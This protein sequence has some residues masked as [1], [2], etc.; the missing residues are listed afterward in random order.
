M[1]GL[2]E[3]LVNPMDGLGDLTDEQV[4]GILGEIAALPRTDPRR[5]AAIAKIKKSQRS[6]NGAQVVSTSDLTAKA[7]F[8]KRIGMLPKDIQEQIRKG[9]LQLVDARLY[10][11][12][13]VGGLTSIEIMQNADNKA[14]GVTNVNNRK[15][16]S[17][18]Y[19]LAT[20]IRVLSAINASALA[21]AYDVAAN[22]VLNGEINLEVGST[23]LLPENT[24]MSIFQTTSCDRYPKGYYRLEN[25][26]FIVPSREIKP[27]LKFPVALAVNT[28]ISF[29]LIGVTLEKGVF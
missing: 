2:G 15:L 7:E 8:E 18:Q 4:S 1:N 27:E 5:L 26:K 13:A 14:V 10:A 16:D 20:G 6:G 24:P 22:D 29:E 9:L 21:A 11:R 12:K 25:P 19:F 28:C 17:G 23:K 3:F